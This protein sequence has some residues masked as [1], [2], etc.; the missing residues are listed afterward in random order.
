MLATLDSGLILDVIGNST[1]R[2][3]L[4]VLSQEPMYFNQLSK[5][6]RI[7]QQSILRHMKVLE[8]SGLIASYAERSDLGAP[9]RKYYKLNSAFS[10]TVSISE[11]TFGIENQPIV[12]SRYGGSKK[13][14]KEFDSTPDET[15]NALVHMQ[16][17]LMRVEK[18]ISELESRLND[19]RALKQLILRK[20]HRIGR[21]T[22]EG[23]LEREVLYDIIEHRGVG[24][25]EKISGRRKS[26]R[27]QRSVHE[28]ADTLNENE[29]HIKASLAKIRNK[30][31]KN[32]A[33]LLLG[34]LQRQ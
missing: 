14:Y 30:L 26:I 11:D 25:K 19:L 22:F 29:Y 27:R 18:E 31:E 1:R 12:E 13:F 28:I 32:S 7:G 2:R 9:D 10:L 20:L 5:E 15:G 34:N 3:I 17:N 8:D 6:I 21:D 16:S 4:A 23:Y 33:E 24:R